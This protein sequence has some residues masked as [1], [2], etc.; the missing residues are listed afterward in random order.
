[1]GNQLD[2]Q[3]L[4]IVAELVGFDDLEQL[5]NGLLTIQETL[6]DA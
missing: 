6:A 5:I 2:W 4:P 1:M 3:A